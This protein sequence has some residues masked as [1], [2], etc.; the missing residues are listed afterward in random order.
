MKV[1]S[2][3]IVLPM[4]ALLIV[5]C[6]PR[7]KPVDAATQANSRPVSKVTL[8]LENDAAFEAKVNA[9]L[10]A[11]QSIDLAYWGFSNDY[12]SSHLA[13]Q[14][15]QKAGEGVKVRMLIN[16]ME[17]YRHREFFKA[18]IAKGKGNLEVAYYR[19]QTDALKQALARTSSDFAQ[20]VL[21]AVQNAA[22]SGA[23]LAVT[24][25][26]SFFISLL[27]P[28]GHGFNAFQDDVFA[29]EPSGQVTED[30]ARLLFAEFQKG[31]VG[32]SFES[33]RELVNYTK[34]MHHKLIVVDKEVVI[35]GGR[36]VAD[37]YNMHRDHPLA[38][39]KAVTFTDADFVTSSRELARDALDSF[40]TLWGC[41]GKNDCS[42]HIGVETETTAASSPE[43]VEQ[44]YRQLIERST[45]YRQKTAAY[46][47]SLPRVHAGKFE[48]ENVRLSYIENRM[49]GV[50]RG[51]ITVDE[52]SAYNK[53]L[54]ELMDA[55]KPD[56]RIQIQN[57]FV[58]FTY[59]M[60]LA[61]KRALARGVN[62]QIITNSRGLSVEGISATLS[63]LQFSLLHKFFSE[64][65]GKIDVWE[66]RTPEVLHGKI[67]AVGDTLVVGS[68]NMDPRSEYLD[69]QNGI[70]IHPGP[71]TIKGVSYPSAA[72]AY[73]SFMDR[74][75]IRLGQDVFHVTPEVIENEKAQ[76]RATLGER[77]VQS[78]LDKLE[79]RMKAS[80]SNSPVAQR[81]S[82]F[83]LA[84]FL[85]L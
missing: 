71:V 69:S 50:R 64:S 68:S 27:N 13:R 20:S 49:F 19:P 75:L 12:T 33:T 10:S 8:Y 46:K 62:I 60:G 61:V 38:D 57:P 52:E 55:A 78:V 5:S 59:T 80:L 2:A 18:L 66:Y 56:S 3:K 83:L 25:A 11:K 4:F 42:A 21:N 9:V 43:V 35:G 77:R 28:A 15:V 51:K 29:F 7:K 34:R 26:P 47:P 32:F 73:Y 1:I 37:G 30:L 53:K 36:N 81:D 22:L 63:R 74:E 31:N 54:I 41:Q 72:Q 6:L 23:K 39:P 58:F 70:I 85:Q 67:A 17:A 76:A 84:L 14:L 79:V 82:D 40:E 16:A 65:K 24:G 44:A 48:L 45:L